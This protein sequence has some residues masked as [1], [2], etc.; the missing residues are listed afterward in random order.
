MEDAAD[1]SGCVMD[2]DAIARHLNHSTFTIEYNCDEKM[3]RNK[4][5]GKTVEEKDKEKTKSTIEE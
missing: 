5:N 4:K 1:D 3:R 2:D